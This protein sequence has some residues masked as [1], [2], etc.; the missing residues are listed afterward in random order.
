MGKSCTT[1]SRLAGFTE[2]TAQWVVPRSMPMISSAKPLLL[3]ADVELELPA[4]RAALLQA[5]ELQRAHLGDGGLEV[6][7][8]Q[9]ALVALVRRER[10]LDRRK[11]LQ[12]V[13]AVDLL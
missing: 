12:L 2:A 5:A 4:S 11:L 3:H 8:R 10:G 7:G 1:A 9:V 6:H 13:V